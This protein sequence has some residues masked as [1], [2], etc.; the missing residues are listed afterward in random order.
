MARGN[1]T[2]ALSRWIAVGGFL[3]TC[4]VQAADAPSV[5]TLIGQMKT[6]DREVRREATFQLE[7]L[8]PKGREA[9]PLL[10]NALDDPDK[11]IW[12]NAVAA[13]AAMGPEAKDAIPKL[14]EG[15]DSRKSRG[16][17]PREKSQ[18]LMRSAYA[19][20]RIGPAAI[21]PLI[22][23]LS[24]DDTALRQGAAKALGGM[25]DGAKEAVPALVKNLGHWDADVRSEVAEAL[26]L[27]GPEALKPVSEALNGPEPKLREGAAKALASMGR[28]AAPAAP[29][30]LKAV[31]AEQESSARAAM[32][33]ALP[34]IGLPP[35]SSLPPLVAAL[36]D[37][38]ED[39]RHAAVNALLLVRPA[40]DTVVPAL[41]PLLKDADAGTAQ[42][43]AYVLGRCGV[44]AR[45]AVPALVQAIRQTPAPAKAA[46]I[47]AVTQIGAPAI[48]ELLALAKT[49]KVDALLRGHWVVA[50]LKNV[51]IVGLGELSKGLEDPALPVRLVA[52]LALIEMGSEAR[53][54]ATAAVALT[55]D[56]DPLMRA[57]AQRAL[58]ALD[59]EPSR[60]LEKIE[61]GLRDPSPMVRAAA[62]DSARSL[63]KDA[64]PL[65]AT[66]SALLDDSDANVRGAA[67]RATVAVGGVSSKN[68]ER[69]ASGL[70]DAGTREA[71][72]E[73][74]AQL[75]SAAAPAISKVAQLYAEA[76]PAMRRKILPV[77]GNAGAGIEEARQLLGQA[78]KDADDEVRAAAVRAASAAE[79][80]ADARVTLL[81]ASLN[82]R[83]QVV[84]KAVAEML[85][86]TAE[87]AADAARPAIA[88]LL[89]LTKAEGDRT[90]ALDAL[91]NLRVRDIS[92]LTQAL[93]LSAPEVRAWACERVIKLG[94]A[95]K[96]LEPVLEQLL[97]DKDDYVRRSA[98][99]ALEA[100]RK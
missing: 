34:K 3:I 36:R 37:S 87:K 65:T 63:G 67:I 29:T 58:V 62:A 15:L 61:A 53:E 20:S 24:A 68:V 54:V 43:A 35:A 74:L 93:A 7:R 42:R 9:L 25:G 38:K 39:L 12:S 45:A 100:I 47:E 84:R 40:A 19:L 85:S 80:N 50:A 22:E 8:G 51:G 52:L 27:I 94:K 48:P 97:S 33:I 31:G 73:A 21:P 66:L 10:L 6:G 14:L 64:R 91:R 92:S 56:A 90:F 49:E 86:A 5:E 28:A 82:D 23:A 2:V 11:Q 13:I 95:A 71:A 17:R 83:A 77:L 99:K 70:G 88:P 41:I 32:L 89:E 30:L 60:A 4:A 75:G 76:T 26:S 57:T 55:T 46:L 59:L 78:L 44:A 1:P 18:A 72:L 79:V 81:I 16:N 69:F 96:E 98:R